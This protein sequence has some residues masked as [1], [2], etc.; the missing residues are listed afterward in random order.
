[1]RQEISPGWSWGSRGGESGWPRAI[2]KIAW[3]RRLATVARR[4]AFCSAAVRVGGARWLIWT[5]AKTGPAVGEE[6][7]VKPMK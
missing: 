4:I 6:V 7:K 2:E 3:S 5:S 1:M